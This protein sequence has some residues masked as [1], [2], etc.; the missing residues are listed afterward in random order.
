MKK[1]F[2][3]LFTFIVYSFLS[4]SF[5]QNAD[6]L[7]QLSDAYN[8]EFKHQDALETLL[9]AD[10][11]SPSNWEILW[12]ISRTHVDMGNRMPETT[13]E[14]KNSKFEVYK[15]ALNYA[16]SAVKLAPDKSVPYVRRA[17]VNGKIALFE[18]VFSSIG[19]VKDV[20]N[21]CERAIQL[22]NG[23]NY[24]Q[25]LAHYVLARTHA[26]VSEKAYLLR[27]PL[28]LGWADMD[29]AIREYNTAIKLKP[30]FRMYYL[31]LA[32]AYIREDEYEPAKEN[33]L[34]VE[35]APFIL[36]EDDEYLEEARQLLTKVNEKIK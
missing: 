29:T 31:D 23:D 33:L 5:P 27:L 14:E 19:T 26:K 9:E 36:E 32:K 8:K 17:I 12:R 13:E 21:D 1:L 16:D 24:Y 11:L 3:L 22:E 20:K 7:I 25:S 34:M 10:E 18:G 30:N 35:K 15:T 28:G 6:E 4:S 2:T